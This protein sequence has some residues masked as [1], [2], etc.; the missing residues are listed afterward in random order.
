[1]PKRAKRERLCI[2]A[3]DANV[4]VQ[5]FWLEGSNWSYL[6][7]RDYLGHTIAIPEIVLCEAAAQ[8]EARAK[9]LLRR[10]EENGVTTRLKAQYQSLFNRKRISA[11][12]PS[13]LAHRYRAFV[14]KFIKQADGIILPP[15]RIEVSDLL[16][17]SISRRKPFNRGDKGFRDTLIWLNVIDLV[18]QYKRV[19][20]V[21]A[22]TT[23][24]A[25]GESLHSDLEEDLKPVL[26]ESIHFRYFKGLP[27][28]IAFIDRD[29]EAGA[30][31]LRDALMTTGYS[32]FQLDE[33]VIENIDD[34][35]AH[36]ELD[37]VGW[38]ALPYHAEDPRLLDLEELVG[39]EVHNQSYVSSDRVEFYCDI[40]LVG[41]FQCSVVGS[42]WT[43]IVH[44]RQVVWHDSK[45]RDFWT[46][47]AIRSIGTFM[48]RVVFDLN[49]ASVV[50]HDVIEIHHQADRAIEGLKEA[51]DLD[52]GDEDP[53]EAPGGG[54]NADGKVSNCTFCGKTQHE[55]RKLVAGPNVFIC[56]ECAVMCNEIMREELKSCTSLSGADKESTKGL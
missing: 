39:L 27:E 24:Y 35:L 40:A 8:I 11:E 54:A 17:R 42:T 5:N 19:S 18:R 55:V 32:G 43:R 22:N 1:M 20:F 41:V 56:D 4:L 50:E 9:D 46:E 6:R 48:L 47:V 51:R 34:I 14:E 44:P 13:E 30:E 33:W 31:A 21:S 26:P 12:T 28:F 38:T 7:K 2:L 10:I 29:G 52:C 45:A 23:D 53:H 37:G 49:T 3:L 36:H 25:D 16:Q 15:P